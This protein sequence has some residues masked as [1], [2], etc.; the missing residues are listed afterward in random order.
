LATS[1]ATIDGLVD[2]LTIGVG[3][4]VVFV[5][6]GIRWRLGSP[7]TFSMSVID[8]LN[9]TVITPFFLMLGAVFWQP[10]LDYLRTTSPVSIAIAGGI[11]LFFVLAELKRL[12]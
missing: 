2:A 8:F 3:L 11:G 6:V 7:Q 10:F 4:A 1:H 9:G 12:E 5:K